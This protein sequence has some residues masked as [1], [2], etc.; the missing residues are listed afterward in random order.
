MALRHGDKSTGVAVQLPN[1]VERSFVRDFIAI[2]VLSGLAKCLQHL[3]WSWIWCL[4]AVAVVSFCYA[5]VWGS[6]VEVDCSIDCFSPKDKWRLGVNHH[7]SCFRGDGLDHAFGNGI[8]MVSLGRTWFICCATSS[9]HLSEGLIVI[10]ST[11]IVEPKSF[12]F[13]SHGV[14]SG[15]K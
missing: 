1:V 13:V 2:S 3:V 9:E 5:F 15:L 12:H 8:L 11:A 6:L 14:N 10:V 4:I 7:G